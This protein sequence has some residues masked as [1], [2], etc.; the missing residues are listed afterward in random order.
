MT[1]L[2]EKV[3]LFLTVY[4]DFDVVASVMSESSGQ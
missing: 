2:P 4:Q 1:L 3:I